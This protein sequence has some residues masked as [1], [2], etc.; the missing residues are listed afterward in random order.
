MSGEGATPLGLVANLAEGVERPDHG[1][2]E[3]GA[4]LLAAPDQC[5]RLLRCFRVGCFDKANGD[6][7]AVSMEEPSVHGGFGLDLGLC[8]SVQT[9]RASALSQDLARDHHR[10]YCSPPTTR[11]H[12]RMS[13][14]SSSAW[15]ET[16]NTSDG[17]PHRD[18]LRRHLGRVDLN[19]GTR[20][21]RVHMFCSR[22]H[23]V[24]GS[25]PVTREG[26]PRDH[27]RSRWSRSGCV[28]RVGLGV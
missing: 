19:A 5:S 9:N 3:R 1:P 26:C 6:R 7:G 21:D 2:G 28:G 14:A 27:L 23:D 22:G 17:P 12:S 20:R 25:S 10:I 8:L 13:R 16:P 4:R 11:G 15:R 24:T 18:A